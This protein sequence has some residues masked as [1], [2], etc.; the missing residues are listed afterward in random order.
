MWNPRV[1]GIA[2]FSPG[3][4]SPIFRLGFDYCDPNGMIDAPTLATIHDRNIPV[5][6]ALVNYH[7]EK[8]GNESLASIFEMFNRLPTLDHLVLKN[9][10]QLGSFLNQLSWR[11]PLNQPIS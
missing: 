7:P 8:S 2:V 11:Q 6:F 3:T 9:F 5:T 10:I 4:T 1:T